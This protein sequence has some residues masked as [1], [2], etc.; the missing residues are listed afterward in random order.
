M[1]TFLFCLIFERPTGKSFIETV[2]TLAHMAGFVIADL[3]DAKVI[4]QELERIVPDLPSV[5]VQPLILKSSSPSVV[6]TDFMDYPWFLKVH[7]YSNLKDL[8]A[9]I[10]DKVV[11][12][13]ETKAR[14]IK[15]RR[16]RMEQ[17]L[18]AGQ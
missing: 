5:P 11:A 13:A 4:L 16:E 10:K 6:L 18:K 3:T 1:I 9:S 7:C 17:S 15:A 12:P 8:L 14:E 2:S